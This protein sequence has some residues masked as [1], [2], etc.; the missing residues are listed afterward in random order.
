MTRILPSVFRDRLVHEFGIYAEPILRQIS[1]AEPAARTIRKISAIDPQVIPGYQFLGQVPWS[2]TSSWFERATQTDGSPIHYSPG[3]QAGAWHIQEASGLLIDFMMQELKEKGYPMNLLLDACAAPGGKTLTMLS[4]IAPEGL[5][6]AGESQRSRLE[7]LL[8][9]VSRTG[10]SQ[11]VVAH[12]DA[13]QWSSLE[14][15]WDGILL[16]MPC[17]GEG[18]F[19]KNEE[20]IRDW[21]MEK[22]STCQQIQ[23]SIMEAAL[24]SLRPGGWL[25][26]STCTFAFAENTAMLRP[27][28]DSGVLKT[29]DIKVPEAWGFTP[30]SLI[31]KQ[32][33]CENSAWWALPGKVEG[34]GFFCAV[35]QK[36]TAK[37]EASKALLPDVG[38]TLNHR[39]ALLK[40][41]LPNKIKIVRDGLS[42]WKAKGIPSQDLAHSL[43]LRITTDLSLQLRSEGFEWN[44]IS[45]DEPLVTWYLQGQN[46]PMRELEEGWNLICYQG[47]G[48]GWI[49]KG[50]HQI[51]NHFPKSR[52]IKR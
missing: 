31:D 30:A 22:S 37:A 10:S 34:E 42:L 47:Y 9:T 48:L 11:V 49:H 3:Y 36:N 32:W 12:A 38:H 6:V 27:W 15:F 2:S 21:S 19:R 46:L 8:E 7:T 28:I 4:H 45:L 23:C 5:L 33:L 52:R 29:V 41:S 24:K 14:N 25:I 51:T 35:F 26:Y 1:T 16:D 44:E 50:G 39:K 20:A 17:S 13:T 43:G 40:N 18:M